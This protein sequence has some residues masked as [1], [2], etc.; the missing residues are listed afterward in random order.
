MK[1]NDLEKI[2]KEERS[3]EGRRGEK[4]KEK[5]RGQ[6]KRKVISQVYLH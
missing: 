6:K 1:S 3:R 4:K 2:R 5:R